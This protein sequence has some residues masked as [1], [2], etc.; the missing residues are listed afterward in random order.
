MA[1]IQVQVREEGNQYTAAVTVDEGG[2]STS[3][4][5]EFSKS[6]YEKLT[7]GDHPPEV[8]VERSFEFLLDRE[9]KES[10]MRK[11]NLTVI[12]RYFGEYESTIPNML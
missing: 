6:Y 11:F 7:S 8:L 4:T 10:I 2:S 5:V 3:H 12:N 9:P 1:N